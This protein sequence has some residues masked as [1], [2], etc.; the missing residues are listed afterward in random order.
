M[1]SYLYGD[2]TYIKDVII[3]IIIQ[4]AHIH[5]QKDALKLSINNGT[6]FCY[7]VSYE[8]YPDLNS[9]Y[10]LLT[11]HPNFCC[12]SIEVY[13]YIDGGCEL[14]LLWFRSSYLTMVIMLNCVCVWLQ[15]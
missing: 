10:Y 14:T 13:F 7:N 9:A 4:Y 3:I 5:Q 15:I 12:W 2:V 1:C 8:S 6:L 11:E